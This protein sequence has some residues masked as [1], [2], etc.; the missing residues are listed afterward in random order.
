MRLRAEMSVDPTMKVTLS[1]INILVCP[2][3]ISSDTEII[4]WGRCSSEFSADRR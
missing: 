2:E 4:I 1:P 3:W